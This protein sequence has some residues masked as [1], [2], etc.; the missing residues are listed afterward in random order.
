[1]SA[2]Q[3]EANINGK[4]EYQDLLLRPHSY[5]PYRRGSNKLQNRMIRQYPPKGTDFAQ[6]PD[7]EIPRI[8]E[9]L[10]QLLSRGIFDFETS[11]HLFQG[12]VKFLASC[13]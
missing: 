4:K 6:V 2:G 9:W 1:M 5:N 13:L 7:K 3:I 10:N 12:H 11:E 8:E